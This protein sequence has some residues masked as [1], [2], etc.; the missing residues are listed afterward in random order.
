MKHIIKHCLILSL[1]LLGVSTVSI[2]QGD[3]NAMEYFI[4]D[5]DLGVGANSPILITNGAVVTESFV[6]PTSGLSVGF[7]TVYF[8]VQDV[9][10]QWSVSN[11]RSFY[12]SASNLTTQANIVDVEYFI[13]NDLGVGAGTSLGPFSSTTVNLTPTIP[14]SGLSAGFHTINTRALDSDG[15]WG[16]LESRSFYISP[17]D[18]T[19]TANIVEVRYYFDIDPGFGNGTLIPITV[20]PNISATTTANTSALPAGHHTL[21]VRSLDSD[22]V[23]SEIESR[24]FYFDAYASGLIA[25]VEYFYNTDPGYGAGDIF[26]IAPPVASIDQVIDLPTTGLTAGP[27]ELGIRMI[28]DN[29]VIGMTDYYPINLC[30]TAIPD[31]V[32]DLVVC[33]G[34]STTFTDN[35]TG[36]LAGDIYSWDF[37]ADGVEDSNTSG[38]QSFT[39]PT[40]GTF[41]ASLTIDRGGC[42]SSTSIPVTVGSIPIAGFT[43]SITCLGLATSLI[44]ISTG[45]LA[46]DIYSWDFDGDGFEDSNTSGLQ[47]FTYPTD[48]TFTASL[49]IDRAGCISTAQVI[50]T[51]AAIPISDAGVDLSF[52]EDNTALSANVPGAGETGLWSLISGSGIFTNTSD[53]NTTFTGIASATSQLRWTVTNTLSGC[54]TFDDVVLMSNLA[55]S[56]VDQTTTVDIGQ[57]INLDV[58]SSAVIN[59]GDVLT[60]TII[61]DPVSG[62]ATV[63]ANG[64]I[65]YTPNEDAASADDL[66]FRITNQCG[67]FDEKSIQITIVNQAPVIDASGFTVT[68]GDVQLIFDLTALISDPNNNLDFTSLRIV[69]QP[70]S[71]AVA[72]IDANGVLTIDY[73]GVTFSGDDQIE[74][75]ICDLVGV[76]TV[77]TIIIPNVNV[78]E[79]N[80]P[81]AVFNAVSPNGDDKHDFLE[82]E[83]IESYP[84]NQVVIFNRWGDVVYEVT[85]YNNT[86]N[87]FFGQTDGGNDLPSGTYYY[88]VDLK[89]GSTVVTGFIMLNK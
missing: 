14:T 70:L 43:A 13:D 40:D 71:G 2:A 19:T 46:G 29:G 32:P 33:A 58:Q 6:L 7:H 38:T 23:W 34:G 61:A 86:D 11:S 37:D 66:V 69:T 53:P 82:I 65:D 56:A 54:S 81:I 35:S 75:E 9:G 60:T 15:F 27:H 44:D 26:P 50:V 67:N 72:T 24:S 41:T 10:G 62:I 39:Y 73:S 36:V 52:C 57:S 5:G 83:N 30:D 74:I 76:C 3:I 28:N 89:N 84:D 8:R 49:T 59:V 77:Q 51:V 16:D 68:P 78:G 63:Q 22:G 42:I 1:M 48:G 20:G 79:E 87:N 85:S 21:H 47:S 55:I 18:L 17:S 12:V 45:T 4:D 25:G 88:S 80:P 64:T 31:F